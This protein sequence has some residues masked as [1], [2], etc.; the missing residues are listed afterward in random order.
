MTGDD[1]RTM[2]Q[3]MLAGDPYRAD[4]PELV[5]AARRAMALTD[6][7][8][9]T[10]ASDPA[11]RRRILQELLGAVGEGTEIRSPFHCDYGTHIRF[12]ARTFA[13]FGLVVLDVA[14][15]T[16][17]DDVQIGPRVQLLAATHPLD[18]EPRRAKWESGAP[19]TIGDNAWL[20]AGVIVCPG[21]TVG[22]D[23]VVAAGAV[24]TRDLPPAVLAAGVPARVV[25]PL[26]AG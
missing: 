13:N 1:G 17:G 20:G 6:A 22:P 7:Y 15:V 3:R 12:G 18:P 9:R 26:A 11:E 2:R 8:N 5:A 23:T 21:V 25:R 19:V 14:P 4:D 16:V 10:P 24:V